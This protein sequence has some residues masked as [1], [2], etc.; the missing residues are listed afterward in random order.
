VD[1][2]LETT[3]KASSGSLSSF[4]FSYCP[5]RMHETLKVYRST[6]FCA[7]GKPTSGT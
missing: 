2:S 6:L 1:E 7:E 3:R 4:A 5:R